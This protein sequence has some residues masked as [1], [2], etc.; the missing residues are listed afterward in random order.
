MAIL[1]PTADITKNGFIGFSALGIYF[2]IKN[3]LFSN[4]RK[5]RIVI[6]KAGFTAELAG[7]ALL[8]SKISANICEAKNNTV[9]GKRFG[10]SVKFIA[11]DAKS[12]EVALRR[13]VIA[14]AILNHGVNVDATG[15]TTEI[16][17]A[18]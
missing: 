17:G 14:G 18:L 10:E 13:N 11:Y 9:L 3:S 15:R 8:I 4:M 1:I 16:F 5:G 7:N 6:I 12:G 2:L